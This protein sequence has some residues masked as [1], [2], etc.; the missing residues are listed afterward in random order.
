M[1]RKRPTV[2]VA[3]VAVISLAGGS[4]F[5]MG[6]ISSRVDTLDA[7]I[8]E[9]QDEIRYTREEL[10]TEIQTTRRELLTEMRRSNEQMPEAL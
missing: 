3:V 8:Q 9:L 4:L 7:Q 10:R 2:V 6:Y 5:W 1:L